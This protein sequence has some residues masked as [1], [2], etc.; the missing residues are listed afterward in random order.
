VRFVTLIPVSRGPGAVA[1]AT[2]T[3]AMKKTS[4]RLTLLFLTVLLLATGIPTARAQTDSTRQRIDAL[5]GM[6]DTFVTPEQWRTLGGGAEKILETIAADKTGATEQASRSLPLPRLLARDA[7]A[8]LWL[9]CS[10]SA[11]LSAAIVS[12]IFSAPPPSVRHCP[13]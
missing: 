1:V 2:E 11:V 13:A 6:H 8:V 12:R 3:T 10:G 4:Q 5:L 9:A 7:F